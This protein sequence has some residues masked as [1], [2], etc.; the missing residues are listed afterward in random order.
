[1]KINFDTPLVNL[2]GSPFVIAG[3]ERTATFKSFA[4]SALNSTYEGENLVY[5]AKY[6][7]SRLARR[8]NESTEAIDIEFIEA[9]LIVELV[10]RVT[11]SNTIIDNFST[12]FDNT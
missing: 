3:T 10:S 12:L 11:K 9:V 7:R 4:V 8:I 2:D 1:M 6:F 5:E